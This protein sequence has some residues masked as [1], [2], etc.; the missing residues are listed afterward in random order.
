MSLPTSPRVANRHVFAALSSFGVLLAASGCVVTTDE[1]APPFPP[2]SGQAPAAT[3]YGIGSVLP[4][5]ALVGY[6]DPTA[7]A[8]QPRQ[9]I[10]MAE[11][12][13]PTGVGV[14]EEGSVFPV[15]TPKPLA[16]LVDMSARWCSVCQYEAETVLP[17]KI[18]K[19][20]FDP[21][22]NPNGRGEFMT[23]LP[24]GLTQGEPA[25]Y[26]DAD[27]WA[28]KF[29]VNVPL[30]VDPAYSFE[31]L[32]ISEAAAWPSNFIIDTRTMTIAEILAGAPD[33]PFWSRYDAVLAGTWQ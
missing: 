28:L 30:V 26:Y 5:F 23:N 25:T 11:F 22:E 10:R 12:Y 1:S 13:N 20:R 14:H 18:R 31:P 19:Y 9:I 4:N 7:Q 33:G 8:G 3:G 21:V 15:G 32:M 17:P 6:V 2:Q 27:R 16:L 24:E 29:Q